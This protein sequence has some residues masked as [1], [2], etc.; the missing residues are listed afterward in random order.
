MKNQKKVSHTAYWR[1]MYAADERAALFFTGMTAAELMDM[2]LDMGQEWLMKHLAI[3]GITKDVA[4]VLWKFEKVLKW[5]NLNWRQYDHFY[6]IP[7]L[8]KVTEG[9]RLNVYK[10]MHLNVFRKDHPQYHALHDQLIGIIDTILGEEVSKA[11]KI[12]S[13]AHYNQTEVGNAA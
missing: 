4:A 8:H 3:G 5:W 1:A 10:D 6:V 2:K 12:A 9:E 11:W 13:Q 7:Y